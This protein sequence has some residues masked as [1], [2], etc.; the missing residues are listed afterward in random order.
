MNFQ[1]LKNPSLSK[2]KNVVIVTALAG[3]F[4]YYRI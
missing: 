2:Y 1:I 3:T 4:L